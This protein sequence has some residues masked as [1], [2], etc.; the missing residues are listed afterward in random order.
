MYKLRQKRVRTI[1]KMQKIGFDKLKTDFSYIMLG[2]LSA[3]A[4]FNVKATKEV[5]SRHSAF[6]SHLKR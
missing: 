4:T 5:G 6:T 2:K 1:A 3:M